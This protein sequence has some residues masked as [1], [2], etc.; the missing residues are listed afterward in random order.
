MRLFKIQNKTMYKAK[1]EE[2]KKNE[3]KYHTYAVYQ[4][5]KTKEYRAIQLTHIYDPKRQKQLEKGHLKLEK[6]SK[7]KYPSGIRN[8]YYTHDI[9]G[10]ALDFGRK[11]NKKSLGSIPSKQAKRI[12]KFATKKIKD[13]KKKS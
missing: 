9:N 11:S 4:D 3:N 5:K 6:L 7:F 12:K 13:K 10:N 1:T 2:D 8:E